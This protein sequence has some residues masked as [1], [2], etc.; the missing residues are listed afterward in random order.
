VGYAVWFP[1]SVTHPMRQVREEVPQLGQ[2][3]ALCSALGPRAAVVEVDEAVVFGYGQTLRS[4]CNVPTI[5]LDAATPAELARISTALRAHG[6]TLFVLAQD[7]AFLNPP[8]AISAVPFSVVK[9]E[10]WPTQVN[11]APK[12]PDTQQ[13]SM[14][15]ATVDADGTEHL[16]PPAR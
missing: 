5:G 2:L 12:L 10:R 3:R 16:L 15:L 1:W 14:Y 13:Y 6:R 9:V 8:A 7:P 11:V 4:F